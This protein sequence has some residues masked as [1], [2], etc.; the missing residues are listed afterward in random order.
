[1]W[2]R[3]IEGGGEEWT[4]FEWET[5]GGEGEG[6]KFETVNQNRATKGKE[7]QKV[8]IVKTKGFGWKGFGFGFYGRIKFIR[9]VLY[10]GDRVGNYFIFISILKLI[11]PILKL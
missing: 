7:K 1:M 8:E 4:K 11:K 10:S 6:A 3:K 9:S 5:K 2:N